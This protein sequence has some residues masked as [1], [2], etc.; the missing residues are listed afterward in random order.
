[1]HETDELLIPC[2][3]RYTYQWR[4]AR[5]SQLTSPLT[6]VNQ[7]DAPYLEH[8][9]SKMRSLTGGKGSWD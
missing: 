8:L 1:M 9:Q 6:A 2:S 4:R 3:R 7:R 5:I